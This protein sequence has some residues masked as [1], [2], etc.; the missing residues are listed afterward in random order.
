MVLQLACFM[1]ILIIIFSMSPSASAQQDYPNTVNPDC[2]STCGDV[3]ITYPFG[4]RNPT[5]YADKWF[6][7][8][9]RNTSQGSKPYIKSI[10]LEVTSMDPGSSNVYIMN[11]VFQWNC[12][13][14]TKY[15]KPVVNLTG[16]PFVYSKELNKFTTIGCNK[17]AFL[18]SN[19]S[20]V[21]GC[22]SLCDEYDDREVNSNVAYGS[23]GCVGRF[24]CETSLPSYLVEYN[25]TLEELT[26]GGGGGGRCSQALIGT[27]DWNRVYP[28]TGS[29]EYRS[30][31]D[32][33]VD[34][35][36]AVL[37][38]VV[39][40]SS[41]AMKTL[42]V[43]NN[44]TMAA[45]SP[46]RGS[47][48]V[49]DC[50]TGYYGNPYIG[51]GCI[52]IPGFFENNNRAK[53][54]AIVGVSSGLGSIIFI[55]AMWF[56]YK[57]VRK[58]MIEKRRQKFFKK[59]GGLLL[60][61]RMSS[62]EANVDKGIL[63]SLKDLK[64]ATD[65]FNMN[66][67]LGKGGQ[68]TVY[69]GMLV[70]GRIVA[71]KKFKVEGNIEEFINEFVILS[72][73][74]N[75]NVVKLLGCCLETEIPLLVYEFIPNG[76][77]FQYLHDQN[78]DL[79]MTWDMRL[80]I[81]TEIAGALFYLHSVASQ[82]I[83]HRDVKSTN[84]LL[85]EKYRAKLADFG[86]SRIISVEATHLTTVVQGTFGY[87]D[88]EYFHTSQFTEKSDVY[89]FGV[90]LA[91]L[92]TCQKAVSFARPGESKNLASYFVQCME[93]NS[94]FDIVDKRITK[95]GKREH[96]IA[97]ANLVKRCLELNGR[98]RPTMKEVTLELE[99]IRKLERKS[100]NAEQ[101]HEEVEVVGI[102]NYQQPWTGYST[103]SNS[104]P[105]LSSGTLSP[106]SGPM[107][108]VALE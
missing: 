62:G 45:N 26:S 92:L 63:F 107:H 51:G 102:E 90:V 27:V 104:F 98:K 76:N 35:V 95:E 94:L 9:C 8:E 65:N 13:N 86:A 69:K 30:F 21:S 53:K 78:E 82:P 33:D 99:E 47:G 57:V 36:R 103:T 106:K 59:N 24:C 79:N 96:V 22:V 20:K 67:V 37:S 100:S 108:I 17:I 46:Y 25:V 71:V 77:L 34:Y 15:S 68:G 4:M 38:W 70:D 23:D 85:D 44:C 97:V 58:R 80:R 101:N 5:C 54:W 6:E 73:I 32:L 56:L 55:V 89:S 48:W 66:R 31:R 83:Y 1:I 12:N 3:T 61:Q 74:N 11:P 105:T 2:D 93:D 72:Q 50:Y 7:I 16:T 64:K 88:P 10:N 91:E 81:A 87:L 18:Q 40:N 14:K 49:C 29:E 75:R 39:F 42:P 60:K 52:A 28:E 43:G 41:A 19:G 84:I